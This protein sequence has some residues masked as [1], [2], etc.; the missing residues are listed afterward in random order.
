MHT[1]G[2]AYASDNPDPVA[3]WP[4]DPKLLGRGFGQ[5]WPERSGPLEPHLAHLR[6]H[7]WQS[8]QQ[9]PKWAAGD[10]SADPSEGR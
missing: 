10:Q 8:K 9:L 6:G 4:G 2:V 3:A 7:G 1:D 5:L